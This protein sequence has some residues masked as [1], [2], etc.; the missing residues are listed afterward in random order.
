LAR[1]AKAIPLDD[2]LRRLFAVACFRATVPTLAISPVLIDTLEVAEK[3]ADGKATPEELS[4]ASSAAWSAAESAH[5][6]ILV[7]L[8]G[9]GWRF[10]PAWRT[11]TAVALACR[12][13][14]AK[15]W[16]S[17]PILAD[18]VQDAGCPE[19]HPALDYLRGDAFKF[20]GA[21]VFDELLGLS[22]GVR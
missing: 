9:P 16:S 10:N 7:N 6:D 4:A 14:D 8:V 1:L 17:C 2:R 21:R 12:I 20:R 22:E 19:N 13:Y 15:E 5:A 11:S 3:F 18:A